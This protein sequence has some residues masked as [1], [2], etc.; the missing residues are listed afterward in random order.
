MELASGG[1]S[2]HCNEVGFSETNV[3]ALCSMGES[4]KSAADSGYI[5]NKG[6]GCVHRPRVLKG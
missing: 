2:F 4:T 6:I 3:L 5:G 1:L